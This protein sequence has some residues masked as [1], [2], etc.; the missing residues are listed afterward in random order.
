MGVMLVSVFVLD[1]EILGGIKIEIVVVVGKLVVECVV[2]KGIKK[3]VFDCG[4][5]FYYGCV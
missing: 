2:E 4:G 3:V 5:Y 1:K